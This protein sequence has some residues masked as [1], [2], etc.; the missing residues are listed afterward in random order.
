VAVENDYNLLVHNLNELAELVLGLKLEVDKRLLEEKTNGLDPNE[1]SWVNLIHN[2]LVAGQALAFHLRDGAW[3]VLSSRPATRCSRPSRRRL[4]T[5]LPKP[6]LR[7]AVAGSFPA[8][9]LKRA[10]PALRSR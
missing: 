2:R 9:R 10:F 1:T 5:R 7:S 6:F 4:P 8:H 3:S